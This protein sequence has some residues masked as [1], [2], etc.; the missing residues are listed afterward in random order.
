MM[1][2]LS[3]TRLLCYP[4]SIP[5]PSNISPSF[6]LRLHFQQTSPILGEGL[7]SILA[8][9]ASLIDF[10]EADFSLEDSEVCSCFRHCHY[11]N[12]TLTSA[13]GINHCRHWHQIPSE[14]SK[15]FQPSGFKGDEG[16][17]FK[18][19]CVTYVGV[20]YEVMEMLQSKWRSKSGTTERFE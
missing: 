19:T 5:I 1:M 13:T 8:A 10:A 15:S 20:V 12:I 16:R 3:C 18:K 14:I 17:I 4:G 7:S 11:G 6:L 9:G 2:Q